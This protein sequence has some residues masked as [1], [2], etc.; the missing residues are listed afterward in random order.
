M[1]SDEPGTRRCWIQTKPPALA[2]PTYLELVASELD[3]SDVAVS[4]YA[5]ASGCRFRTKQQHAL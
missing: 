1:Q 5:I 4:A 3:Q 2:L